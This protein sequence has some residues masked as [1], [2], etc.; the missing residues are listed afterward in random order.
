MTQKQRPL[1]ASKQQAAAQDEA[2]D[3]AQGAVAGWTSIGERFGAFVAA[4]Q[5]CLK[6]AR[7]WLILTLV[8]WAA[9]GQAEVVRRNAAISNKIV[10][11]GDDFA[12]G[13]GDD[14]P[15]GAVP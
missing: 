10:I 13:I 5:A 11:I 3:S 4:T 7:S 12:N 6:L 15:I 9:R 8:F 2:D 14:T 1:L